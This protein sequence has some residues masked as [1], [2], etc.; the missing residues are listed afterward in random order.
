ML[1]I[2]M[3]LLKEKRCKS[4]SSGQPLGDLP[5]KLHE[6]VDLLPGQEG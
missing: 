1:W 6:E 3:Q 2:G 4:L 5:P